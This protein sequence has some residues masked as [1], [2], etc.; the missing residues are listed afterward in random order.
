VP[1][2]HT[3]TLTSMTTLSYFVN[4]YSFIKEERYSRI[5]QVKIIIE[6]LQL[7]LWEKIKVIPLFFHCVVICIGARLANRLQVLLKDHRKENQNC[8][9]CI[10]RYKK[11][12]LI[13]NVFIGDLA[14]RSKVIEQTPFK[15]LLPIEEGELVVGEALGL[16]VTMRHSLTLR[17]NPAVST[18]F[19]LPF[20]GL[21]KDVGF[22]KENIA[23]HCSE[24][25]LSMQRNASI[26]NS[27]KVENETFISKFRPWVKAD[28]HCLAQLDDNFWS[29]F[30]KLEESLSQPVEREEEDEEIFEIPALKRHLTAPNYMLS[31]LVD[32]RS[33][34]F[35]QPLYVLFIRKKHLRK[36]ILKDFDECFQ[37]SDLNDLIIFRMKEVNFSFS[38]LCSFSAVFNV[39]ISFYSCLRF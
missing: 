37:Q 13:L 2:F 5:N 10:L 9:H 26:I 19:H 15:E 32:E 39:N 33:V 24:N 6:S 29:Y 21:T 12:S 1:L 30:R 16:L 35:A 11:S 7:S 4:S 27:E 8:K 31:Q 14:Q 25:G 38:S 34:S 36:E 3:Y 17:S 28:R 23:I 18:V 22:F 20:F